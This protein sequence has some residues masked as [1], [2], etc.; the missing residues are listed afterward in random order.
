MDWHVITCEYAPTVGG[1]ADHT[2]LVAEGLAAEGDRVHV[3]CPA[4]AGVG[5]AE[6]A[7]GVTVRREL[8]RF[9]PSDLRRAG[10]ALNRV[11]APRRLLVQWVPHGYG[12]RSMNVWFCLWLCAR[13]FLRGDEVSFVVHEPFLAFGE[14]SWRQDAVALVHRLM[15]VILLSS[16]SRV[17]TTIPEWERCWRPYALGRRVAFGWLPVPSTTPATATPREAAA[18]RALY[19]APGVPLVGHFGT[20]GELVASTLRELLPRLLEGS[21]PACAVL[22]M[23]RGGEALRAELLRARPE[24]AG[25]IHATGTLPR[26]ELSRHLAAC[27]LLVQPY[28]DGVSARRTSVMAGLAHGLPV[29]TTKGRL[30]EGLWEESGA[31]SLH[32]PGDVAGMAR[33]ARELL[34]DASAR[35]NL[36]ARGRAAYGLYFDLPHLTA[37]LRGG[38]AECGARALDAAPTAV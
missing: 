18:T 3:W 30:T 26:A 27:D 28:P 12:Y 37:R 24:L 1:V 32:E 17:W 5:A 9:R 7:R 23:G 38:H 34:G 11:D 22:L 4:A 36:G 6:S 29:V 20:Y 35:E 14:G 31:V 13:V 25:R 2:R 15:T 10:R 16:A 33:A 21:S 8:G 19:A